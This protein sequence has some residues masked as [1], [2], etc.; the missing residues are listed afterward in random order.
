MKKGLK[1]NFSELFLT[2]F[3]ELNILNWDQTAS[4]FIEIKSVFIEKKETKIPVF[5]GH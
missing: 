2:I 5:H 1:K 3:L 4:N